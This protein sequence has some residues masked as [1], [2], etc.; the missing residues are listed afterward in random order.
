MCKNIC[1]SLSKPIAKVKKIKKI[2]KSSYTP[3]CISL[4]REQRLL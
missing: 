4:Q 1:T 3:K 2:E